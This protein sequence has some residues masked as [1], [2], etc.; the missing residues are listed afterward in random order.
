MTVEVLK[1][2]TR[3]EWLAI[4]GTTIGASEIAALFGVHPFLTAFELWHLKAGLLGG[5]TAETGPLRRGRML[6]QVAVQFLQE[7]RPDWTV[8]ANPMPGGQ[9][10]RDL[11]L[12]L[13]ATPDAFIR[14]PERRGQRGIC[15]IK[16]V[17]SSAFRTKWKAEDGEIET[18]VYVALQAIQEAFLTGADFAVTTPLVVGHGI[19]MP[20]LEVPMHAG[21]V[22]QIKARAAAFWASIRAG[23]PPEP[24]YAADGGTIAALYADDNGMEVDLTDD[25]RLPQLAAER[26]ELK[27]A[28]KATTDRVAV[29]DA[30]F[31]HRIGPHEAARLGDGRRATWRTERRRQRFSPAA[32]VRTLRIS[33]A[34]RSL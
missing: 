22:E 4:R 15:Q 21:I 32:E 5:D 16:S 25:A 10:F 9:F 27:A 19:E 11:S 17:E 1:P 33:P 24:D 6:E 29:I 20:I 14:D 31:K 8:T 12:G 2:R 23:R 26:D 34:N 28:L 7:E 18:P 30:E 13:S 3:A